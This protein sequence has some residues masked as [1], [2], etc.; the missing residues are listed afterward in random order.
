M[1]YQKDNPLWFKFNGA[2]RYLLAHTATQYFPL[3]IV[4]EYPKSGGTWVGEMLGDIL[5]IPFPRNRLPILAPSILHG[6]MMHSWNMSNI[7]IVWRDG[8]DVLISQYHHYLLSDD[9]LGFN[10]VKKH[11]NSLNFSNYEDISRDR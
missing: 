2:I 5:N 11:R 10:S 6:H 1:I 9:P 3:F 8:R 4:N 7:L